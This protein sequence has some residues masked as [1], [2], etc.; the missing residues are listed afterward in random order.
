MLIEIELTYSIVKVTYPLQIKL[1][2]FLSPIDCT[3]VHTFLEHYLCGKVNKI[4]VNI[5]KRSCPVNKA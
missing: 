2:W 3:L 4:S 1:N 5:I